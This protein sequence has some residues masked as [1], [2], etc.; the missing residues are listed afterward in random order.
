MGGILT[1]PT[2]FK[3]AET[4]ARVAASF[5]EAS[6]GENSHKTVLLEEGMKWEKVSMSDFIGNIP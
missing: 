1:F 2:K 3:S 4:G 6:S 5:D